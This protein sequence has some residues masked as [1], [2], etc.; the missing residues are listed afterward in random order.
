MKRKT[1]VLF[2]GGKEDAVFRPVLGRPL[3][4]YA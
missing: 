4:A 3:G 2:L 1:V